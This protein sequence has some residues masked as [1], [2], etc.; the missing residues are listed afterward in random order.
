MKNANRME[1]QMQAKTSTPVGTNNTRSACNSNCQ[2]RDHIAGK[3]KTITPTAQVHS[4]TLK[5]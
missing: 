5:P 3:E 1:I 2:K 4:V